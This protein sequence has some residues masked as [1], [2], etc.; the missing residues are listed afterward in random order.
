MARSHEA[1]ADQVEGLLRGP[2]PDSIPR[3]AE[4]TFHHVGPLRIAYG[5]VDEAYG[6]G[7][8]AAG[9]SCDAGDAEAHGRARPLPDAYGHGFRDLLAHGA[10]LFDK[11][12]RHAREGGLQFV[13]VNDSPAQE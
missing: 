10:V 5:N 13:R 1:A 11:L 4:G 2:L 6:L 9:G 12:G 3:P 7:I 8:R